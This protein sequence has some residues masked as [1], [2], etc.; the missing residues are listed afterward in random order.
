[1]K[2]ITDNYLRI[3]YKWITN[4][5][6]IRCECNDFVK[7]ARHLRKNQTAAE[8]C[9]WSEIRNRKLAGYKFYRQHLYNGYIFDFFNRAKGLDIEID[10]NIHNLQDQQELDRFRDDYLS[11]LGITVIRFSNEEVIDNINEVLGVILEKR[12]TIN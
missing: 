12:T 4:S 6:Q 1:M 11:E 2:N 10:G 7:M 9:L 3:S 5:G 8:K